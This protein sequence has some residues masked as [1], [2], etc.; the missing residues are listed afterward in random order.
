MRSWA[1]VGLLGVLGVLV[2]AC[3]GSV[4]TP[5]PATTP[6]PTLQ[7]TAT[8]TPIGTVTR[9]DLP[10]MVLDQA[11]VDAEFPGLP[12]DVEDSG[13][14]DNEAATEETIDP[15]DT[16]TDLTAL[17]RLDGYEHEFFDSAAFFEGPPAAGRPFLMEVVVDL[18]DSQRSAQAFLQRQIA[19]FR[20]FQGI[21]IDGNT[22]EE[23]QELGAHDWGMDAVAARYTL[24]FFEA[25]IYVSFV[26]WIR[27]PVVARVVVGT[28][29]DA[30]LSAAV[31]RLG[32]RMDQRIDDVLAGEIR[33]APIIPPTS[34][35]YPP[36][37]I[38]TF[39]D[40]N[41][42]TVIR[43][44][45]GKQAGEEI[46]AGEL[47][48]LTTLDAKGRRIADLSS[49]RYCTNLFTLFLQENLISDLSPL[50]TLTSLP[51]L[52][53]DENQISDLSPLAS[54]TKLRTLE[55]PSN[56]ISDISPLA[57]LTNLERLNLD[58]LVKSLC[59]PN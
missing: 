27:G 44:A 52:F 34:T 10:G 43:E 54:L 8:L 37:T 47:A 29:D 45:L 26:A 58:S 13:S 30:D 7:P 51:F 48:E 25:K 4:V 55:L 38:V 3:G 19:D 35:P 11:D 59:R 39:P 14:M 12:L 50:A 40:E 20:R 9:E 2:A 49:I 18:F 1:L 41:L 33:V 31:N 5:T 16:A 15:D 24:V 46:T 23:F 56:Q 22:V 32:L 42:E 21:E 57:S 6:T 53:L 17:G 36:S 28:W